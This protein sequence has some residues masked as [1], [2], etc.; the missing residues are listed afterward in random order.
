[1]WVF[2]K[3]PREF[4]PSQTDILEIVS[5]RIAAEL[6]REML[7][8]EGIEAKR[9]QRQVAQVAQ[10]R[11]DR[12]PRVAP[13]LDGW[14]L[15]GF[16]LSADRLGG[17][18]YDWNVLPDGVLAVSLGVAD[19]EPLEAALAAGEAQAALAA[20]SALQHD[21]GEMLDAV[22]EVLYAASA[23]ER[24]LSLFY[25]RL[26][27]AAGELEFAA[28]GHLVAVVLG[29]RPVQPLPVSPGQLA[30]PQMGRRRSQQARLDRGQ[31]LL[32]ASEGLVQACG[33]LADF[34]AKLRHQSADEIA[35]A[36][37]RRV[38]FDPSVFPGA[39]STAQPT[40]EV[41]SQP[42][43]RTLLVVKRDE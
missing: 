7:L 3:E 6:E 11:R 42:A 14:Q 31:T 43:A 27:P 15:A 38:D 20:R 37:R 24:R 4:S 29:Q 21:C 2:G 40:A 26:H 16:S 28:A 19:G 10:Q 35:S 33:S 30:E 18:F 12:L 39:G 25:G 9:W 8:A 23:E 32:V 34:A 1:L 36:L 5:G 41:A 17:E 13:L 22:N